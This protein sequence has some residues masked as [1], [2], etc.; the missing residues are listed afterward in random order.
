MREEGLILKI[1]FDITTW[2]KQAN[3]VADVLARA[4]RFD[5]ELRIKPAEFKARQQKVIA[6]LNKAG[7]DC[8][9]V[10]SDEHYNGDV[11]YLG[12]NTNISIEPVAGIIAKNGFYLLAGLEGGYCAEQLAPRSGCKVRKVEMLKLADEDYPVAACR[13]EDVLEE[14]CGKKPSNMALLTPSQVIPAGLYRFFVD[15][16]G[17]PKKVVDAQEIYYKIKYI[18]SDDE[19]KL[20]EQA[21]LICDYMVE[22]MASVIRPGIYE[23]QV[24]EWGNAIGMELGVEQFGFDTIVLSGDANRTLIGKA[25][26]RQI[27]EGDY[28]CLGVAPKCDGLTSC[29]RASV[30]CV[31]S[32][33]KLTEDQK[34]WF[35]FVEGAYQVGLDAYIDVAKY[36]KPAKLQEQALVDYFSSRSSEVSKRLGKEIDMSVLK[37]YTGTHNGGYTECQEFYGAITLSSN[38]PLGSQIVTMLDVAVRGFGNDWNDI[39]IPGMDYVLVEKTLGKYG[40]ETRVLNKLPVNIQHFVGK[41][42]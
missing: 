30:V 5:K 22:G 25:L 15:Y 21:S 18:K 37:P 26:N 10:Y 4:P 38:E 9:F 7:Y 31:D 1:M 34:Y 41:G 16:F 39:R 33:A 23:T 42:F 29:E 13:V 8:G 20:I 36:N 28:V 32:P 27:K 35:N 11:P 24:A 40:S 2:K 6:E 17:G 12:G 14:A 3:I 19:M